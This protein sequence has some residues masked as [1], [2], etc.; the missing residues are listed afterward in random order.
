M[1][2]VFHCTF[3]QRNVDGP[4]LNLPTSQL[5]HQLIASISEWLRLRSLKYR[6]L[7]L[8]PLTFTKEAT[9]KR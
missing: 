6:E 2:P 4:E 1:R 3:L 7:K 5:H 8:L 9:D